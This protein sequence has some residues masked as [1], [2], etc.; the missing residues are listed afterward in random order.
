MFQQWVSTND[1]KLSNNRRRRRIDAVGKIYAK[2][3]A[4]LL[5]FSL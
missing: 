5:H 4:K 3:F 1:M 2:I